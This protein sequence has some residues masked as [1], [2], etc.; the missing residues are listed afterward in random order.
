VKAEIIV[1]HVGETTTRVKILQWFKAE[2]DAVSKGEPLLEVE[3]D[4]SV[5]TIEA[6]ADGVL[7]TIIVPAG[8]EADALQVIGLL[9]SADTGLKVEAERKAPSRAPSDARPKPA[10]KAPSA[11]RPVQ[12]KKAGRQP[13]S[14]VAR[15]L[16]AKHGIDLSEIKGSGP[17]GMITSDD[18]QGALKVAEQPD[19]IAV[20]GKAVELSRM[21]QTI[22]KR[23]LRSKTTIPHFYVASRVDMG[24]AVKLREE[25][26]PTIE[27]KSGA[28]LS[29]THL[30]VKALAVAATQFPVVNASY[31]EDKL[32]QHEQVNVGIA[33]GLE[34]GLIV[35]VLKDAARKSLAQIAVEA[36]GLVRRARESRLTAEDVQGGT[37]TLTNLGGADVEFFAAIINPPECV[38]VASGEVA[39]RPV[40]VGGE[41]VVR[42]TVMLVASG[43]HRVLDGTTLAR[44]LNAMKA[45]LEKPSE[46]V[47]G[48]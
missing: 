47:A 4:K 48:T 10:A 1:P 14:P 44:F 31:A 38:I 43:D 23:M 2:G 27:E 33:V 30:M 21:R 46:L 15:K 7:D 6:Y 16:A 8:E 39:P 37:I 17:G 9:L 45:L 24:E 40:V 35:P 29:Y 22:G 5:L 32:L 18:V 19:E 42:P 28:R 12:R 13:V 25:L 34:N 3:T 36:T 26:L 20:T 11:T 41:I